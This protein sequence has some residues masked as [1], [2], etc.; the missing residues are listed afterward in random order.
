[1]YDSTDMGQ[2][3]INAPTY[4]IIQVHLTYLFELKG[5]SDDHITSRSLIPPGPQGLSTLRMQLQP[6][7]CPFPV[8]RFRGKIT[9]PNAGTI[10]LRRDFSSTTS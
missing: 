8:L 2:P 7:A 1:M 9:V 3:L 5:K 4:P 10:A 6:G